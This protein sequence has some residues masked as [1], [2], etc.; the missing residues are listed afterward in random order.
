MGLAI[1]IGVSNAFSF[2]IPK[3]THR[4]K[5]KNISIEF[6]Y[7]DEEIHTIDPETSKVLLFTNELE[8][9]I[10]KSL[11]HKQKH[12]STIVRLDKSKAEEELD[13]KIY[14]YDVESVK[15]SEGR[16]VAHSKEVFANKIFTD[17]PPFNN[18]NFEEFKVI[19]KIISDIL[20]A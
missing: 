18:F 3:P 8:Q 13:K 5:Y 4:E 9:R 1:K 20:K 2:Y 12:E 14:S 10:S 15:D 16:V 17:K 7:T 11:T 6:Y 19:F